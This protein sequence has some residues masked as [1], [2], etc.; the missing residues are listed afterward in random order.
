MSN[1]AIRDILL[2]HRLAG[3]A[4][5]EAEGCGLE[6]IMCV[7]ERFLDGAVRHVAVMMFPPLVEKMTTSSFSSSG[8]EGEEEEPEDL[9][10][11]VSV[12]PDSGTYIS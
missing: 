4:S 8:T 12:S 5:E 2:L 3:R 7:D 1:A 10:R 6:R 9:Y 11:P